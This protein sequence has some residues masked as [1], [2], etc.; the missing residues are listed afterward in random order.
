M[1]K[2]Y[3]QVAGF[4]LIE[5]LFVLAIIGVLA[6][7]GVAM[8]QKRTENF[9]V[10]KTALQIQHI[11]Q[12]GMAWNVD[13]NSAWPDTC[14]NTTGNVTD[15]YRNYIGDNIINAPWGSPYHWCRTDKY[16]TPQGDRFYV[17]AKAKN[18][19]TAQRIAVLLP[20]ADICTDKPND[21][22]PAPDSCSPDNK[23]GTWVRAY[24]DIPGQAE[25]GDVILKGYGATGDVVLGTNA[26]KTDSDFFPK[27]FH[28]PPSM[29]GEMFF[30]MGRYHLW[31]E[32]MLWPNP[33]KP[34]IVDI[35][36]QANSASPYNGAIC[37]ASD[38]TT[39]DINCSFRLH[40][41][42]NPDSYK[43][44]RITANMSYFFMCVR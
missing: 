27:T 2:K 36:P 4:T 43:H 31:S 39:G 9:K 30:S 44:E 37:T 3:Q 41:A 6:S 33:H 26:S 8:L 21:D 22:N 24:V 7:L 10:H 35:E 32:T 15:F 11:L 1:L 25:P 29:H 38:N 12:S 34:T 28:C 17:D 40:I 42:S 14:G 19:N 18:N 20:S 5:L 23:Q 16:A 13:H